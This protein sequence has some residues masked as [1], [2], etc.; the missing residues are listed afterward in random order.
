ME[1]VVIVRPSACAM[2]VQQSHQFFS[3]RKKTMEELN[4]TTG[5]SSVP[6][7]R[8]RCMEPYWL[9]QATRKRIKKG[10]RTMTSQYPRKR[11]AQY[12]T[13]TVLTEDINQAIH[14]DLCHHHAAHSVFLGQETLAFGNWVITSRIFVFSTTTVI[15]LAGNRGSKCC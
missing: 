14:A 12:C 3:Y 15:R 5:R 10:A 2:Q 6:T 11:V 7:C 13:R 9:A 4:S 8:D 1:F